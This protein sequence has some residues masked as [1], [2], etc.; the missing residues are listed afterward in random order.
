MG[1]YQSG[2]SG[3]IAASLFRVTVMETGENKL[4]LDIRK[5]EDRYG[6]LMKQ[7]G[8]YIL[9]TNWLGEDAATVWKTYV[10][11]SEVEEAFRI[12]GCIRSIISEQIELRLI[13]WYVFSHWR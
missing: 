8:S 4:R 5:D 2:E 11:L 10:Q 9:R 12:E 7:G 13:S 3:A 6:Q 1:D